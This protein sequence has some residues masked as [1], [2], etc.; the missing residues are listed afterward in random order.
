[1]GV[2]QI[3]RYGHTFCLLCNNPHHLLLFLA[4]FMRETLYNILKYLQGTKGSLIFFL[5]A[6]MAHR[7]MTIRRIY[8][9]S[10]YLKKVY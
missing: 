6:T 4:K 3:I 1:M 7:K 5:W 9:D 8:E 10:N 2:S